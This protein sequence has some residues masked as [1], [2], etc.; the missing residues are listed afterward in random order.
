[1][2]GKNSGRKSSYLLL[3]HVQTN[4]HLELVQNVMT[5]HSFTGQET[6]SER[7]TSSSSNKIAK[8]R[9]AAPISGGH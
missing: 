5:T 9:E 4:K 3:V 2:H 7:L 8:M 1:M 6:S